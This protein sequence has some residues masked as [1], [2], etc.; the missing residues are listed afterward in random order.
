MILVQGQSLCTDLVCV[1][2]LADG[3]VDDRFVDDEQLRIFVHV[4]SVFWFR[5]ITNTQQELPVRQ[6]QQ[7]LTQTS[8]DQSS[9]QPKI[10]TSQL[11]GQTT[12]I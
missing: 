3:N 4:E 9:K 11:L 10:E 7:K 8:S 12:Q 2:Q 1:E 6:K 5:D